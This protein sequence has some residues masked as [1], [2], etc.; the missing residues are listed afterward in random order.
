M[1]NVFLAESDRDVRRCHPVMA[2]LRPHVDLASFV[3]R[4]ERQRAAYGYRLVALEVDDRI[5]AV[6]GFRISECLAWGRYLYVDDL[7]TDRA[8]RSRG[9]GRTLLDWLAAYARNDGCDELHLDSGVQRFAAHRFYLLRGMDI[10][11]HHFRLALA[12]P[13]EMDGSRRDGEGP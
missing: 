7:V 2:Q 11:S 5:V 12:G 3:A 1:G 10:T 13:R 9:H 4:V 6:A 8:S